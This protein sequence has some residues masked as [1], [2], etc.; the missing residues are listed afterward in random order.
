MPSKSRPKS[1]Q[2]AKAVAMLVEEGGWEYEEAS[3]FVAECSEENM[4][5]DFDGTEYKISQAVGRKKKPIEEKAKANRSTPDKVD[6]ED[7]EA[8]NGRPK[9]KRILAAKGDKPERR[10][11]Q[12]AAPC[13]EFCQRHGAGASHAALE[14][15]VQDGRDPDAVGLRRV[16]KG[17]LAKVWDQI[18]IE[19][20]DD[21]LGQELVAVRVMLSAQLEEL[22]SNFNTYKE[23]ADN[24][25]AEERVEYWRSYNGLIKRSRDSVEQI[26]KVVG[27]IADIR[28]KNEGNTMTV[29]QATALIGELVNEMTEIIEDS[30]E[31]L[32]KLRMVIEKMDWIPS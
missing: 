25:D 5:F 21:D 24:L 4:P 1:I 7:L 12:Y 32:E 29:V 31:K 6:D 13:S 14:D 15:A 23:E 10:C 2:R 19:L 16:V 17:R 9:C 3:D 26:R 18:E 22:S 27:T 8:K 28:F 11:G 20:A 30:P